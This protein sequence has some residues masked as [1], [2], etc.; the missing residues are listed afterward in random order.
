MFGQVHTIAYVK[1]AIV[2]AYGTFGW[3]LHKMD[4][5]NTLLQSDLLERVYM[6]QP[7]G[8]QSEMN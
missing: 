4:V 7:P 3:H 2:E 1:L 5:K 6:I 8:F